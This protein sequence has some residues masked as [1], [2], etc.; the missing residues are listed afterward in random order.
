MRDRNGNT[1]DRGA[2][3]VC[4]R[5]GT[6]MVVAGPDTV[7]HEDCAP[8]SE[9]WAEKFPDSYLGKFHIC[10]AKQ[11]E[12]EVLKV[13]LGVP[14]R[15][16]G[17]TKGYKLRHPRADKGVKRG[18]RTGLAAPTNHD[19]TKLGVDYRVASPVIKKRG[20]PKGSKNKP[21]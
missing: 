1:L 17:R 8:G 2:C 12:K 3:Y 13:E 14:K 21:K 10:E 5:W 16:R 7:R 20:R 9:A 15:G 11:Q 19:T 4:G 6:R 18:P